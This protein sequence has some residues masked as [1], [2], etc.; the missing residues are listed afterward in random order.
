MSIRVINVVDNLTPIN[1]GI[2]NAAIATAPMLNELYGIS[3]E[4]WFPN[5][6]RSTVPDSALQMVERVLPID[7][8]IHF[9]QQLRARQSRNCSLIVM[10]H[11]AWRA[12]TRWGRI[13]KTIG[14]KWCHTPHGMLEPWSLDQKRLRKQIY[15]RL[16]EKPALRSS[17]VIRAVSR[18]EQQN[19]DRIFSR[20][21]TI[22]IPNGIDEPPRPAPRE[23]IVT[24]FLYLGRLHHKKAVG[25]LVSA[26][27]TSNL[28]NRSD[29]QLIVAGPDDGQMAGVSRTLRETDTTNVAVLGPV[30]GEHK[31]SLLSQADF[32]VLPSHSEGF[33]TSVLEAMGSGCIPVISTGCNFPE[34][35]DA[36][37]TL[38]AQPDES[39]IRAA[40]IKAF[41]MDALDRRRLADMG[42]QFV[43]SHYTTECIARK[44]RDLIN[45]LVGVKGPV[46][47]SRSTPMSQTSAP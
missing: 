28:R 6:Q 10:T 44:Q 21:K 42:A 17:D 2:W 24:R 37:L 12:P 39:S 32:F 16:I 1:F 36:G 20:G 11:G 38:Q 15:F 27:A 23:G 34:A 33:P 26:F 13:A 35:R 5:G 30:F 31:E 29:C 25:E 9:K 43:R 7:S 46:D 18:P 47:L 19:L 22:L 45:E 41:E 4:L 3:S 40:L 14:V 8:K